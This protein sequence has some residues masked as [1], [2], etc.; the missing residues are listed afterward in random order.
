MDSLRMK[1]VYTIGKDFPSFKN[2]SVQEQL[3]TNESLKNRI[4]VI[5]FWFEGCS[6]CRAETNALNDL[7][8]DFRSNSNFQFLSFTFDK[9]E[10]LKNF[11]ETNNIQYPVI[12]TKQDSCTLLNFKSGYPTT[13][14]IN[15][16]GKVAF[17]SCGGAEEPDIAKKM[18]EKKVY[19]VLKDLLSKL[20]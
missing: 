19:P 5:N 11:I 10:G 18:I 14:I 13:L 12:S 6:P 2:N 20:K 17:Y 8:S 15:A 4:T 1:D 7:Y 9:E 3:F 16:E